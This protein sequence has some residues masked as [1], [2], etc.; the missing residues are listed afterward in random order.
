[1]QSRRRILGLMMATALATPYLIT[2]ALGAVYPESYGT[3]GVPG[4]DSTYAIQLALNTGKHVELDPTK[5]YKTTAGLVMNKPH[6]AMVG[7]KL[8]PVGNFTAVHLYGAFGAELN[9]IMECAGQTGGWAASV[10]GNCERIRIPK[11]FIA[12]NGFN[13]LY[14]EQSNNVT[15]DWLYAINLRGSNGVKWYGD[16]TKRSDILN[17][18]EICINFAQGVTGGIGLDW[19]G[20]CHSLNVENMQVVGQAVGR[21]S[22]DHA[23]LIRAAGDGSI[24]QIGR[25][26]NF[27]SDFTYSHGINV[28]H[29]DDIDFVTPYVNGSQ[30]GNGINVNSGLVANSIRFRGGKSIGNNQ[31]GIVGGSPVAVRDL[32]C[33]YNTVGNVGGTIN[34]NILT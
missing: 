30:A 31:Y 15:V 19:I 22:V 6:Q 23:L 9:M 16:L 12:D 1:M 20:N 13:A 26:H 14:V 24:P 32:F 33:G 11:L 8:Q 28:T 17:L 25:I 27:G 18:R 10:Y 3:A 21:S 2:G 5:S 7:G 29:G 4:V 34:G